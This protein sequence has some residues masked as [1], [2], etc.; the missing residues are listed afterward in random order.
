MRQYVNI[1]VIF[2]LMPLFTA[3][4]QS[5]PNLQVLLTSCIQLATE[6]EV[7]NEDHQ[8]ISG[9]M[10]RADSIKLV[11]EKHG[12]QQVSIHCVL[13]QEGRIDEE[14]SLNAWQT[15]AKLKVNSQR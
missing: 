7:I 12:G 4:S 11:Y 8:Y 1:L 15:E 10:N 5:R 13:N 3:C 2:C 9:Y 14:N 6:H